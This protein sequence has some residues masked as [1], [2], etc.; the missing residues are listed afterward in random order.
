MYYD[1]VAKLKKKSRTAPRCGRVNVYLSPA[2]SRHPE[3]ALRCD[4]KAMG[5]LRL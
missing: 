1:F 4:A 5:D 2:G 3:P